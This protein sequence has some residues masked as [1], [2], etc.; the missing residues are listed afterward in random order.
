MRVIFAG[1][2]VFGGL[3][4]GFLAIDR[5]L[6]KD[7]SPQWMGI[8]MAILMLF[9][10]GGALVIFNLGRAMPK[11]TPPEEQLRELEEQGVLARTDFTA[12]RAFSVEEFEDEGLHFV[13]ELKD[14]GILYLSGQYLYDCKQFPCTEFTVYRHR[15]EDWVADIRCGGKAI[16]TEALPF[17]F[18]KAHFK[19]GL[20]PEDGQ[21][22]RDRSY[23]QFKAELVKEYGSI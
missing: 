14:G 15:D 1:L 17:A 22:W 6:P 13:I 10:T 9:L 2:F 4:A 16:E 19:A 18:S 5:F 8:V 7:L 12:V 23:E 21:I 20:V 3:L 11:G